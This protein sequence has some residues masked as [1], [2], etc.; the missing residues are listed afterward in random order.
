[1]RRRVEIK[2]QNEGRGNGMGKEPPF[3]PNPHLRTELFMDQPDPKEMDDPLFDA[4]SEV[5]EHVVTGYLQYKDGN[6]VMLYDIQEKR[7]YAFQYEGF[8]SEMAAKSQASLTEQYERAVTAG[9]MVVFVR[10]NEARRLV[11]YSMD[12]K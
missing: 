3:P 7:I 11:S 10:D 4:L 8:K 1:M 9:Q 12:Y 5:W 2:R 6:P